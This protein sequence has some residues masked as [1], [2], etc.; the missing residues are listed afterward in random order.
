MIQGVGEE[1]DCE[2]DA[3]AA[4]PVA[5]HA[6]SF[7]PQL[8]E[9]ARR[10]ERHMSLNRQFYPVDDPRAKVVAADKARSLDTTTAGSGRHQS[11]QM[12]V[13]R[14]LIRKV[15]A[16]AAALGMIVHASDVLSVMRAIVAD[17]KVE[18]G[19][20]VTFTDVVRYDE[21]P[22]RPTVVDNVLV[23]EFP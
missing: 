8:G 6:A 21:T 12:D 7:G 23:H 4:A 16:D 5:E 14:W 19:K 13:G 15:R 11:S 9:I 20:L 18:Q 2:G 1:P 3:V 22:L 10:M 17:V